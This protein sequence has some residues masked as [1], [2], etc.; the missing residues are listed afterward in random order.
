MT[1]RLVP[2]AIAFAETA[3]VLCLE[4]TQGLE[5]NRTLRQQISA[6]NRHRKFDYSI[7]DELGDSAGH[8]HVHVIFDLVLEKIKRET[9]IRPFDLAFP[10]NGYW[11]TEH[12]NLF[13]E[14][15]FLQPGLLQKRVD[16]EDGTLEFFLGSNK[17]SMDADLK[18]VNQRNEVA[19]AIA[20]QS[21]TPT[22][23]I[24]LLN[25]SKYAEVEAILSEHNLQM[26]D[27]KL[28]KK[29]DISRWGEEYSIQRPL[30]REHLTLIYHTMRS[31]M[32]YVVTKLEDAEIPPE[33]NR[34][35]YLLEQVLNKMPITEIY[36]A[37]A[38]P[39]EIW[40]KIENGE[41]KDLNA[42]LFV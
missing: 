13:F 2:P 30:S 37:I 6:Q 23:S 10:S 21:D 42:A 15:N 12:I 34:E 31:A 35:A 39:K 22:Y 4:A 3:C 36:G 20:N 26:N 41:D 7:G 33:R 17:M 28:P 5:K 14:E 24:N 32:E 27:L 19:W 8:D 1:E 18:N 25:D 11:F 29:G 9:G 16:E 40:A 38:D